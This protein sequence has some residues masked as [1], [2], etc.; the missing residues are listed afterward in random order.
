MLNVKVVTLL[1][2]APIQ[3]KA[4]V[5]VKLVELVVSLTPDTGKINLPTFV[6][7]NVK[8]VKVDALIANA[9]RLHS[10]VLSLLLFHLEML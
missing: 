1:Q 6:Q 7:F 2:L 8:L 9:G 5:L 10:I 4:V 3:G